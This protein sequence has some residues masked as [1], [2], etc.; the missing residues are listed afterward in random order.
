[1]HCSTGDGVPQDDERAVYW[2]ERAV[3]RD[4]GE[5]MIMLAGKYE[6][7]RG[8]PQDLAKAVALYRQA[9][10]KKIPAA[11]YHL[12]VMTADGRGLR[13]RP[14][15]AMRL[16]TLA[17][18]DGVRRREGAAR[19]LRAGDDARIARLSAEGSGR[20]DPAGRAGVGYPVTAQRA[21]VRRPRPMLAVGRQAV[22]R[23]RGASPRSARARRELREARRPVIPR[24][25]QR[26]SGRH[27]LLRLDLAVAHHVQPGHRLARQAFDQR[28]GQRRVHQ[29]G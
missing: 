17:A 12:G 16:M 21:D 13:A 10:D 24:A 23:S 19:G 2:L 9:A 14:R 7:G 27:R 6:R 8:V 11:L 4:H 22:H 3:Q 20:S 1:M 25:G 15:E 18:K 26:P 5:A 28:L 29:R